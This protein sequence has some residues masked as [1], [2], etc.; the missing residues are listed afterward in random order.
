VNGRRVTI[1]SRAIGSGQPPFLVAELSANHNG[2]LER[3]LRHVR[4]ARDR[5]ADAIKFQTYTPDTLTLQSNR[6]DFRI[7]G[8]TWDGFTLYDLYSQAYM[9]WEWHEPLFAEARRVGLIAFSTAFDATAVDLLDRLDVPAIKVASFEAVDLDLLA[10]VASTGRPVILS[11]GM[12]TLGEIDQAVSTLRAN[13]CR[14]LVLLH[15]VSAY[16]APA[17]DANLRTIAHMADAFDVP[18]GLS[19]HTTGVSVACAAV[20]HGACLIEKHFT[21]SRA[22]GGPDSTFSIEPAELADLCGGCRT[23]WEAQGTV[24]YARESS[25]ASSL[26]FRRSIYAVR[27]IGQGETLSRENVRV[28]RPGFGLAPRYLPQVLGRRARRTI[29]AGEPIAWALFE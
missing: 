16:P 25:E 1:A 4:E 24:S 28:I 18:V 20:A 21:L 26:V 6:E 8:G 19:D 11:T 5:G 10:T 12:A 22:D 27:D 15:C 14:E 29:G 13:G 3:A 17:T 7:K 2:S 23:A 9:P